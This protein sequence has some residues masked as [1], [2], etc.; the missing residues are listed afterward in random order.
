MMQATNPQRLALRFPGVRSRTDH[1]P[2]SVKI[3]Q[4]TAPV[5]R[6]L[7]W[8]QGLQFKLGLLFIILLAVLGTVAFFAGF[9]VVGNGLQAGNFRYE[10]SVSHRLAAQVQLP[11]TAAESLAVALT[12]EMQNRPSRAVLRN[13]IQQL[14]ERSPAAALFSSIGIWPE[15]E[16]LEANV[17]RAS[18]YLQRDDSGHLQAREDYND[19]SRIPYFREAWY[20]P[21]RY[22]SP[23]RCFW[24]VSYRDLLSQRDVVTCSMPI[25]ATGNFLGVVTVS[26]DVDALS[27]YFAAATSDASGYAVLL[28]RDNRVLALSALAASGLG[29][30]NRNAAEI[31]QHDAFFNPLALALNDQLQKFV[32][33]AIH[34]AQYDAAS[35]S[36]LKDATRGMSRAEAESAFAT[37]W[38]AVDD[39]APQQQMRLPDD[40]VLHG[41]SYAVLRTLP[42][43]HWR[44]ASVT[45]AREGEAGSRDL[46]AKALALTLGAALLTLALAWVAIRRTV[47]KPLRRMAQELAAYESSPDSY[48]DSLALASA[49]SPA[50]SLVNSPVNSSVN[51]LAV[52][53]DESPR[54]EVGLLAHWY[55]ERV[56]QLRVEIENSNA[57]RAD[58]A[59]EHLARRSAQEALA[60]IQE[61]TSL[62]LGSVEDGVIAT[63]EKGL[64]EELNPVAERLLG[65]SLARARGLAFERI[66]H[67]HLNDGTPLS[68][69]PRQAIERGVRIEYSDGVS[70]QSSS[71]SSPLSTAAAIS[72]ATTSTST[73][74]I[75]VIAIPLRARNAA[76]IGCIIVFRELTDRA[77]LTAPT[78][79]LIAAA[80]NGLE[81]NDSLATLKSAMT[82]RAIT[83]ADDA[84][85]LR[86]VRQGLRD[87]LFH[88]TTQSITPAH[89][90]VGEGEVFEILLTL[91]D[92]EGFWSPPSVFLPV[93]E[94]HGLSAELD[95]WV[96]QHALELLAAKPE[97]YQQLSFCS[98]NL[99]TAS[100]SEPDFLDFLAEQFNRYPAIAVNRFC[101]E[102]PRDAISHHPLQAQK[103]CE[104]MRSF[105]CRVAAD[106]HPVTRALELD[107][108]RAMPLDFFKL[109]ANQFPDIGSDPLQ[110]LL[111]EGAL[112]IAR[113]LRHRVIVTGLDQQDWIDT[114]RRLGPDYFQGFSLARPSAIAFAR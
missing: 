72:A 60:R 93:A 47:V 12:V 107:R 112:R 105:G 95:R 61:R 35:I 77:A 57:A 49:N 96:V 34:S 1:P 46:I 52:V 65:S 4:V 70:L 56:L 91:E 92:E 51:S 32:D 106:Y 20:T 41:D 114:W 42:G 37:I 113:E 62:I 24:T 110:Q 73:T 82:E 89:R 76:N 101:F 103:F 75:A 6:G 11:V 36:A 14:G 108:L 66:F 21:V 86:R 18:V 54:D 3:S 104:A 2:H 10:E 100:L 40:A 22:A 67:A 28:D 27:K 69:L 64:I 7:S 81:V 58:F 8:Y 43:T 68:D 23:R 16:T 90:H 30:G 83:E 15:P 97:V 99:T 87:D 31:A 44:I 111:G 55:N 13:M 79:A 25:G 29:S 45:A 38:N 5:R 102:L 88:L 109:N 53:L 17:E 71:S 19:P 63:D 33:A 48:A 39:G 98:I 78:T 74:P 94:R 50:N 84:L 9:K 80:D 59:A 85:Q 26:L